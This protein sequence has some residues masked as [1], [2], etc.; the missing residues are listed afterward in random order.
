MV[1]VAGGE[2]H[3]QVAAPSPFMTHLPLTEGDTG[4]GEHVTDADYSQ[5][6]T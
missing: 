2:W 5:T 1:N 6:P 4:W 3:C